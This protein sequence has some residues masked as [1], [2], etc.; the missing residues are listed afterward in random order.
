[1]VEFI[2]NHIGPVKTNRAGEEEEKKK[3]AFIEMDPTTSEWYEVN[4][5]WPVSYFPSIFR[6]LSLA[7]IAP[8]ILLSFVDVGG[9]LLF[10][11]F[12]KPFG[13]YPMYSYF[14]QAPPREEGDSEPNSPRHKGKKG[15]RRAGGGG[16]ESERCTT[17]SSSEA[18]S[19]LSSPIIQP[20]IELDNSTAYPPH[21][22]PTDDDEDHLLKQT[23]R[24][25][26]IRRRSSSKKNRKSDESKS[27]SRRLNVGFEGPMLDF[28]SP[29]ASDYEE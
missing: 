7:Y 28:K 8:I 2:S 21:Q 12:Y 5:P 17:S 24:R 22:D 15:M 29:T 9:Y 14:K 16:E 19:T 26:S 23:Q 3:K 1:M 25:T 18:S 20:T 27:D 10:K 11:L 13:N 6:F 4:L